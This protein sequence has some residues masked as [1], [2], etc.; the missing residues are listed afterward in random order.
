MIEHDYFGGS[1]I[2]EVYID[3]DKITIYTNDGERHVYK[4]V[5]NT[6]YE[7]EEK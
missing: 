7:S 4:V 6:I 1:N 5:D 2:S 3:K